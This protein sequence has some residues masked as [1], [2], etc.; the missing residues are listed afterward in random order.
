MTALGD[1]CRIAPAAPSSPAP[2]AHQYGCY[3]TP[4]S[5]PTAHI[6][7]PAVH[8][9]R[10]LALVRPVALVHEALV[11]CAAGD[12]V[13]GMWEGWAGLNGGPHREGLGGDRAGNATG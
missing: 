11:A 13:I 4:C 3:G 10:R 2:R 12:R 1:L 6:Q 7:L 5:R 8:D 9:L